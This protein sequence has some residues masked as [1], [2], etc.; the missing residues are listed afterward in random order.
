VTTLKAGAST[1]Y[2]TRVPLRTSGGTVGAVSR[3]QAREPTS[4]PGHR[5]MR[6]KALGTTPT[7]VVPPCALGPT[8]ATG[9]TWLPSGSTAWTALATAAMSAEPRV[10]T[11]AAPT[12]A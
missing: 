7:V 1:W 9:V 11:V 2:V 12:S 10:R 8:T 4:T 3:S 6:R 5:A